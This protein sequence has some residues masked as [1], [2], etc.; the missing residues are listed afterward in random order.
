MRKLYG[1]SKSCLLNVSSPGG[2][3]KLLENYEPAISLKIDV[4]T[5]IL[6]FPSDDRREVF[7]L[8][9]GYRPA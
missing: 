5:E 8:L 3:R 2:F 1:L 6:V 9:H 7:G 4:P